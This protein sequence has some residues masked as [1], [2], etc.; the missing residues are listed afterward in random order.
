LHESE[1][2]QTVR[3]IARDGDPDRALA[4]L[5]ARRG[6]RAGLLA[7]IAFGGNRPKLTFIGWKSAVRLVVGGEMAAGDV[8]EQRA[9]AVVGGGGGARSPPALGG[10]EAAGEQADG[11]AST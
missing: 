11:G 3:L 2:D 7:L 6:G 4:A 10:G 1:R 5:F 9:E 8:A